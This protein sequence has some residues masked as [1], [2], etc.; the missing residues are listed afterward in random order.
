MRAGWVIAAAMM[1]ASPGT[2][3]EWTFQQGPEP[4]RNAAWICDEG[5]CV[6]LSCDAGGPLG[7]GLSGQDDA[8][9][10]ARPDLDALVFVGGTALPPLAFRSIGPGTFEAKLTRDALR[11]I[12]RLKAGVEME[13][14]YW[15]TAD[16]M[17]VRRFLSLKGSRDAITA[18]EAACPLP[19][20]DAQERAALTLRDPASHVL[21]DMRSA[22]AVLDGEITEGARF[23]E[24]I[25]LDGVAPEDLV[26]RHGELSCSTVDDLVCG[27]A[28]CLTSVWQAGE[29]G[30][31]RVFLNAVQDVA[32]EQPGALRLTLKG[33]LCGRI[34]AGECQQVWALQ[35]GELA[36]ALPQ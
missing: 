8:D 35:D 14:L 12:E 10:A 21:E 13:V 22:C 27:P 9:L 25:D 2:A 4:G 6:G 11:G 34:G 1:L 17:P 7:F 20:F 29:G 5:F 16:D 31:T 28:G 26:L 30:Y 32:A 3:Q 33:S 36:P 19:D 24:A 23:A 18:V 15:E